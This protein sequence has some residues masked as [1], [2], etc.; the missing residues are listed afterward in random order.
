MGQ[1]RRLDDGSWL[2]GRQLDGHD[3]VRRHFCL[4]HGAHLHHCL[5]ARG[6]GLQPLLQLHQ[7]VYFCHADAGDEQQPFAALLWL[8]G[9]R[10]GVLFADRFL[11]QQTDGGVCQY[12]SLFGQPRG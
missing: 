4:A 6:R 2:Y 9:G 11:V 8:G 10:L 1:Y 5:Y 3:D 12:E 7:L